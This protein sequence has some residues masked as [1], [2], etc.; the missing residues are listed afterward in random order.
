MT[1]VVIALIAVAAV[2]GIMLAA[3]FQLRERRARKEM[4]RERV[5]SEVTG[6]RQEADAHTSRAAELG[7]QAEVHREQ[8]AAHLEQAEELERRAERARRFANRHGTRADERER[9]LKEI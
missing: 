4:L 9:E 1:I 7:P 6:H 5:A 2:C 8:A 3:G